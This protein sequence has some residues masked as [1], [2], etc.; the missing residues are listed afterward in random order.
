M[1][2]WLA[3]VIQNIDKKYVKANIKTVYT[4]NECIFKTNK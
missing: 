3:T 2:Y 4:L 1:R